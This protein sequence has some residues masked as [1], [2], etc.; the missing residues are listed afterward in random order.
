MVNFIL[1]CLGICLICSG[2]FQGSQSRKK[3]RIWRSILNNPFTSFYYYPSAERAHFQYCT[4]RLDS[5][6]FFGSGAK[7]EFWSFLPCFLSESF[8]LSLFPSIGPCWSSHF[9]FFGHSPHLV[10][11]H[12]SRFILSEMIELELLS[13]HAL[14]EIASVFELCNQHKD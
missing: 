12:L 1:S 2:M 10:Y 5:L 3:Y 13:P 4:Y 8:H 7:L 9:Y 6:G 14:W 11:F